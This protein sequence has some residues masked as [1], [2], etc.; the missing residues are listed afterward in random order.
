MLDD[1]RPG[2]WMESQANKG[3]EKLV[4]RTRADFQEKERHQFKGQG[5][6]ALEVS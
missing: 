2:I 6:K 1:I 5:H 3:I 4:S